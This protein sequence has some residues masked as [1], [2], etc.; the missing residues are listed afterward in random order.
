MSKSRSRVAVLAILALAMAACGGEARF[1]GAAEAQ[2]AGTDAQEVEPATTP[3]GA[4]PVDAPP[5]AFD[6]SQ[7]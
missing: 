1:D 5:E 7:L 2:P 6:C 3:A 4:A